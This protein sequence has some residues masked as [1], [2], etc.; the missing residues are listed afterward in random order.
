MEIVN[1]E[2]PQPV[3]E[4]ANSAT[5]PG[6][7]LIWR[8]QHRFLYLDNLSHV[9]EDLF[10]FLVLKITITKWGISSPLNENDGKRLS[11]YLL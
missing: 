6:I 5:M 7:G 4:V 10:F 8:A 2:A 11:I 9:L 1:V 3:W